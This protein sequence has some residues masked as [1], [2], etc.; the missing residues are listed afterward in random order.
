[1]FKAWETVFASFSHI[2]AQ[3]MVTGDGSWREERM[4]IVAVKLM[5]I[6]CMRGLGC[7]E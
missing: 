4:R 3:V 1:M 7:A 6:G 5:I 2:R